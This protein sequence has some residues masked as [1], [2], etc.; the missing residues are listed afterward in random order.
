M[1]HELMIGK[2]QVIEILGLPFATLVRFHARVY[3][4]F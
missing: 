3:I 4:K 2:P 1:E